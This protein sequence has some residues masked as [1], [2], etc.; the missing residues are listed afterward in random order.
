LYR[1]DAVWAFARVGHVDKTLFT[2]LAR[3]IEARLEVGLA[4]LFTTL[5]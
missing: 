1:Y 2:S 3:V 5:L 4:A